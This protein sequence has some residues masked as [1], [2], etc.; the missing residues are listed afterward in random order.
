MG[1]KNIKDKF[2]IKHIV[3]IRDNEICIGSSYI[4]DLIS[5]SFEGKLL[6]G[7]EHFSNQ[8]L[9]RYVLELKEAE[10]SG[11]LKELID[12]QDTFRDLKPI[13]TIKKGRVIE[14]YC[15]QYDY[16]NICTDG[17][18]IYE[19]TFWEKRSDAVVEAKI[20][21]KF[22]VKYDFKRLKEKRRD[23]RRERNY[24]YKR[25]LKSIWEFFISKFN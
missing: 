8:E 25:I 2:K 23:R 5:I 13:Y 22:S 7:D 12:T 21:A 18:L 6:K 1:W 11:E 19:N 17:D 10:K 15:E 16:P 14:K 24:D 9:D 20:S 4:G 3:Q